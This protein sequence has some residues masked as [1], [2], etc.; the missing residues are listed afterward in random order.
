MLEKAARGSELY[1]GTGMNLPQ[2]LT[3]PQVKGY[4]HNVVV[5]KKHSNHDLT[6]QMWRLSTKNGLET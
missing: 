3:N 5:D 4:K 6:I 2:L 1:W